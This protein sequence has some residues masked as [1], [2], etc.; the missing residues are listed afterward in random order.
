[1]SLGDD[2]RKFSFFVGKLILHAYEL[3]YEIALAEGSVFRV[4]C[5]CG[6]KVSIHRNNSWHHKKLAIDLDLF[7]DGK[8]LKK[9]E[10]HQLLGE[11][12]KSLDTQCTWGGDFPRKDGNHYSYGEGK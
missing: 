8:Y 7:K 3:G 5:E 1:M 4:R 9:T 12:W 2:Q 11:Y 6:K 10:D